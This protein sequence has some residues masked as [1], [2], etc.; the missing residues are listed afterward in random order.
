MTVEIFVQT[1]MRAL[2]IV[3]G[4]M[5]AT[6]LARDGFNL[7]LHP[8]LNHIIDIYER[9][10]DD[11]SWVGMDALLRDVF[12]Q[13]GERYA[14]E[15]QLL[16]HWRHP[17]LLMWL[18]FVSYAWPAVRCTLWAPPRLPGQPGSSAPSLVV[19][20]L[21]LYRCRTPAVSCGPW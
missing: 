8:G 19:P 11:P 13:V 15:L 1:L 21:A 20:W 16:P 9:W 2:A 5:S 10:L 3:V 12:T 14:I 18:V 17:M 7:A 4:I 6:A